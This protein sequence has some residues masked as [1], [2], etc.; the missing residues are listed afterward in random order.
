MR[1]FECILDAN[2]RA[3]AGD[4]TAAIHPGD[5]S[6]E[7]PVAALTCIDPR[8]NPLMPAVLGLPED[9]F[10]WLRNAGNIITTPLSTTM[11]SLALACAIKGAREIAVI[12]HS[13]CLVAKTTAMQL[14]DRF[15]TLG[16]ERDKLP[17]NINEYFGLF[18]SERQ[19]VMNTV[20]MVRSSPIIGPS[21]PVQGLLVDIMTGKLEWLVNGYETLESTPAYLSEATLVANLASAH[22][23][24]GNFSFDEM[25]FPQAKIG[26]IVTQLEKDTDLKAPPVQ[27]TEA[28]PSSPAPTR[29]LPMPRLLRPRVYLRKG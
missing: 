19:N 16:I 25:R 23:S 27:K 17:D 9:R 13:D 10:I 18:S 7:L 24:L 8:L 21:I 4:E 6:D 20:Q 22:N 1:L 3:V 2:H 14:I 28:V 29:K 5:F 26:E 12:G 15:R 11:R